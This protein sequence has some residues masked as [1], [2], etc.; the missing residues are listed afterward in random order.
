MLLGAIWVFIRE[1][2]DSAI[3]Y[4]GDSGR[5]LDVPELGVIPHGTSKRPQL[6]ASSSI[7]TGPR[8]RPAPASNLTAEESRETA[9][10]AAIIGDSFRG[11]LASLLFLMRA[12]EKARVFALTSPCPG[13]GKTVVTANLGLA[14][15]EV[16]SR[17][18]LID[19]DISRGSLSKMLGFPERPGL[20]DLLEADP[21]RNAL[22]FIQ[23]TRTQGLSILNSGKSI[24]ALSRL[25]HSNRFPKILA[26][27]RAY[28]DVIIID[29]PPVLATP[30]ARILGRAS[31]GVILVTR[32]KRTT[33]QSALVACRQLMFDGSVLVGTILNDCDPRE[34]PEYYPSY[35]YG[36]GYRAEGNPREIH[37][38]AES[39]F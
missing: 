17:V 37:L 22:E 34:T 2:T 9:L 32:A 10:T 30:D 29:T 16:S 35:G 36:H 3:R 18:L 33:W 14:L 8:D 20:V 11:V 19:G 21:D 23:R 15:A 28:F 31:D 26:Q 39:G 27:L 1:S 13:E 5:V 6:A 38:T 7:L 25:L 4:P 24:P 12:R